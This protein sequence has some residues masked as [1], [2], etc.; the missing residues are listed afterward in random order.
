MVPALS[1]QHHLWVSYQPAA[2]VPTVVPIWIP[3]VVCVLPVNPP[4]RLSHMAIFTQFPS[5]FV[6][7]SVPILDAVQKVKFL[8]GYFVHIYI[9]VCM[10]IYIYIH[11]IYVYYIYTRIIYIYIRIYVIIRTSPSFTKRLVNTKLPIQLVSH[12]SPTHP[13][14]AGRY[15]APL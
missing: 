3:P 5:C 10:Y 12:R 9:H 14:L 6:H 2:S 8:V 1:A 7:S 13:T 15:C 4:F 11:M